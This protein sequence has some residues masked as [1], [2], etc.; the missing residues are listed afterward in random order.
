MLFREARTY[1]GWLD[2]P[3]SDEDLQAIYDL[4][5]WGPTSANC[6][7]MRIKFVKNDEA[8]EKLKPFPILALGGISEDNYKSTLEVGASG[9]AGISYFKRKKNEQREKD[10]PNDCRS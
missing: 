8:R 4:T 3:V 2:K 7:P 10:L 9:F 5:K 6:S 1:N